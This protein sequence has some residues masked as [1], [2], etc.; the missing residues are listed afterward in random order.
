MNCPI[1]NDD[2]ELAGLN[3]GFRT[4]FDAWRHDNGLDKSRGTRDVVADGN[5]VVNRKLCDD[6]LVHRVDA[7]DEAIE[8]RD[9]PDSKIK[10]LNVQVR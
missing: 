9:Q 5:V 10:I 1:K 6:E 8:Q 7:G 2:R 3:T 4:V